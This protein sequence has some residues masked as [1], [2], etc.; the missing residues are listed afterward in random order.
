MTKFYGQHVLAFGA[1]SSVMSFCLVARALWHVTVVLA[2]IT[3]THYVDDFPC[4]A[5]WQVAPELEFFIEGFFDILGWRVKDLAKFAPCFLALGVVFIFPVDHRT[6][7]VAN[8]QA[9]FNSISDSVFGIL[10]PTCLAKRLAATFRGRLQFARTQVFSKCGAAAFG[11]LGVPRVVPAT[12][13][14]PFLLYTDGAC[15]V[16]PIGIVKASVGAVLVNETGQ[17]FRH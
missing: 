8:T 9:R 13:P 6:V 7:V 3:C 16:G 5:F 17:M 2:H 14:R 15:E 4:V 11:L 12:F 10:S 1:T